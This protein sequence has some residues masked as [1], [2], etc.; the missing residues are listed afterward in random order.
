MRSFLP[1]F[2]TLGHLMEF[3]VLASMASHMLLLQK[4]Y[5]P[6]LLLTQFCWNNIHFNVM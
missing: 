4:G 6:Y 2:T 1:E 5:L 3:V